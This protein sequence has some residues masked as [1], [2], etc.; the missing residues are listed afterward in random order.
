MTPSESTRAVYVR[1]PDK[2]AQKLDLA[3]ARFG[4]SKR[5]LLSTLISEHLDMEGETLIIRPHGRRAGERPQEGTEA[6]GATPRPGTDSF[7][8]K[9]ESAP[10]P[11]AEPSAAAPTGEVLTLAEAAELLRVDEDDVRALVESGELPARRI[12]TQWRL[13][14][15]ALLAWLGSGGGATSSADQEDHEG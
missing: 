12:G 6:P 10:A 4:V 15:T 8:R 3:A 1:M 11:P 14:R 9:R 13:T 5:D 2:I 7:W